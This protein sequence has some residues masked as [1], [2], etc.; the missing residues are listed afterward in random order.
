MYLPVIMIRHWGWPGF[1]VFALPN[2]LGCAGFGYACPRG[3]STTLCREHAGAMVAFSAVTI[4]Y[5]VFFVAWIAQAVAAS[6]D[7][8]SSVPPG[9]VAAA[10]VTVVGLLLS[11]GRGGFWPALGS[12]AAVVSLSL[13]FLLPNGLLA[14]LAEGEL[15]AETLW[16]AVPIV[17]FGF[18]L[19]P[20][21]DRT[22][23]RARQES[24]SVHAFGVFGASFAP[25]ILLTAAYGAGGV[26]LLTTAVVVHMAVQT[27]F[28]IAAH[29]REVRL[30]PVPTKRL[31]RQAALVAPIVIG[32]LAADVPVHP[33]TSYL[34]YLGFYGLVFPGYVFLF[35]RPSWL[36]ALPL[37]PRAWPLTPPR[38]MA[39]GILVLLLAP[40]AALGFLEPKTWLLPI[41]VVILMVAAIAFPR[42]AA[43]R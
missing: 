25:I 8:A 23:H 6:S 3:D 13:W 22:F 4:S 41:P 34:L 43:A 37:V 12:V 18:L 31:A 26:A 5:Q 33:E 35:M 27:T 7:Y 15:P 24:P 21:L 29:A 28:T 10:V 11:L 2:V 1:L 32:A 9:W 14:R 17:T 19:S 42:R 20:W 36:P 39:F 30:A 16:W 38:L 40:F